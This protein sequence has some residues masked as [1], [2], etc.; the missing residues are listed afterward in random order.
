MG[1]TYK[2]LVSGEGDARRELW[3]D[4]ELHFAVAFRGTGATATRARWDGITSAV[5]AIQHAALFFLL[6]ADPKLAETWDALH[7]TLASSGSEDAAL[8][9]LPV[10][11]GSG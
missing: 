10:V 5:E 4:R 1:T 9:E 8:C 6:G 7:S 2:L 11:S 3:W